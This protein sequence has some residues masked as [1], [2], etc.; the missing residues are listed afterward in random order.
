MSITLNFRK[1]KKLIY[2]IVLVALSASL[3]FY[4]LGHL[5]LWDP[6][7]P[8]YAETAKQMVKTGDWL[9]PRF[10]G[11]ERFDKPVLFYW[12]IALAYK[13]LGVSEFAARFWPALF[14]VGGV[15]MAYLLGKKMFSPLAGF[16]A[17]LVLATNIQYMAVSRLAITD[18]TLTFFLELAFFAFWFGYQTQNKLKR[19]LFYL[20]FYISVALATLT[21]G[22]VA[23][24]FAGFIILLFL[25]VTRDLKVLKEMQIFWGIIIFAIVAFPW[26]ILIIQKYGRSYVDYFF[27]KHNLARFATPELK[28]PGPVVYYLPVLLIGLFPWSAFLFSSFWCLWRGKSDRLTGQKK[29]I[30]FIFIWFFTIFLFFSIAQSKLPT[31][32][33]SL[34]FPAAL[35]IGKFLEL[36][37]ENKENKSVRKHLNL[38]LFLL[39]LLAVSTAVALSIFLKRDCPVPLF[40]YLVIDAWLL[41][42]AFFILFLFRS[43]RFFT[44]LISLGFIFS[45]F[46]IL[47]FELIAPR[48]VEERSLK[49]A[50]QKIFNL[51]QGKNKVLSYRFLKPSSVFY[52][53]QNIYRLES[54]KELVDFLNKPERFFCWV[55]ADDEYYEEIKDLIKTKA[56]IIA[57]TPT[58]LVISN[59]P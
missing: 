51:S 59:Y 57:K 22:P 6:D 41:L 37:I 18:M 53:N 2:L 9:V 30:I 5:S 16:L 33:M 17:G 31:Y 42:G 1:D 49:E 4:K 40:V 36:S 29:Q 8:R 25:I 47:I 27:L 46:A 24:I 56:W 50:G 34:Y 39:V 11:Q 38:S 55:D 10:N 23:I 54:K 20:I 19:N 58:K 13:L 21:K 43:K 52:C 44:A 15:I 45:I 28:H 32:I 48:A 35:L 14:G 26:Y 3:F 12:L 7:E